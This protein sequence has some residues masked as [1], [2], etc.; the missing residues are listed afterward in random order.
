MIQ[1][2]PIF[3]DFRGSVNR[4]LLFRQCGGKT[5][6]SQFPNRSR[7]IYSDQQKQ[8]QKRFSEAVDFARVVIKEPGLRDTYSIKASLLGFRSAW[9]VA[10]AEFMSEKPL[11]VKKKKIRFDKSILRRSLGRKIKMTLYKYAEE[12]TRHVLEMGRRLRSTP[13]RFKFQGG[14]RTQSTYSGEIMEELLI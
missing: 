14:H 2:S 3:K 4:H 6:V 8:A 1:T 12:P 11:E 5:V 9:N 13:R 10:I 7:V